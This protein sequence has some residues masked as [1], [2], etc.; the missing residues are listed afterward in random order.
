MIHADY[1]LGAIGNHTDHWIYACHH[2]HAMIRLPW[3]IQIMMISLA[4]LP[5]E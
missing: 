2:E 1:N 5:A 4:V 3:I